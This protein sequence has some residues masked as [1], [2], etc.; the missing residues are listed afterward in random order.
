LEV[1]HIS[2]EHMINEQI[3]DREVR[4]IDE[5]G[6]QLGIMTSR[7]A[8]KLAE[9]KELD[10][11]KIAPQGNPPVCKI[12]DYGK[13]RFENAKREKEARKHQKVIE[14]KEVRLSVS[15]DKHD[16]D[17]KARNANG[18]LKE[19]DKVKVSIRFKGRQ[20]GHSEIGRAVM[21]SFFEMV[22]ENGVIERRPL[23][24][25]RTMIMILTPKS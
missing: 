23:M 10:L 4:V 12:M 24:E 22:K 13:F 25:G 18:F 11:V 9:E 17:F 21:D 3:R 14:I 5:N 16:L 8:L 2:T 7:D 6:E 15:I 20:I 1:S 19:G